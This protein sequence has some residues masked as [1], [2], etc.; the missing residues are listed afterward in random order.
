MKVQSPEIIK[1]LTKFKNGLTAINQYF[2]HAKMFDD[3][4]LPSAEY[5]K[6]ESIDDEHADTLIEHSVSDVYRI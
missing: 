5:E 1:H 6:H 4:G 2:L 3:W